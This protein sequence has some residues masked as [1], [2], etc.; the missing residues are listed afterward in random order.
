MTSSEAQYEPRPTSH[1]F[2]QT[3]LFELWFVEICIVLGIRTNRENY[4]EVE[5][6][7]RHIKLR[8]LTRIKSD[9]TN[10]QHC[11]EESKIF[12]CRFEIQET[13]RNFVRM[14]VCVCVSV[15]Q[16]VLCIMS[17]VILFSS[18]KQILYSRRH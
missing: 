3:L 11:L 14:Y 4:W 7:M 13:V 10:N 5:N 9:D 17:A 16:I 6:E 12:F 2:A 18:S 8:T 15:M 1:A